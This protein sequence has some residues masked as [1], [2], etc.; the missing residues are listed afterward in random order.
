MPSMLFVK[1]QLLCIDIK[2]SYKKL[3]FKVF[4]QWKYYALKIVIVEMF[5]AHMYL[6]WP[7]IY[8]TAM[9]LKW[10]L[11]NCHFMSISYAFRK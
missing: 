8:N 4:T 7:Y 6:Q 1:F 3:T 5:I 2:L 11:H 10:S 9:D